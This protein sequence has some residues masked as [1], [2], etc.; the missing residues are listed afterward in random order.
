MVEDKSTQVP[1]LPGRGY[2]LI[3][4]H[5]PQRISV[6]HWKG[7]AV[8]AVTYL[9]TSILSRVF[10]IQPEI[11]APVWLPAGVLLAGL[12][13][14]PW[15]AV[16]PAICAVFLASVAGNWTTHVP[17]VPSLALSLADCVCGLLA[18]IA[19]KE[20]SRNSSRIGDLRRLVSLMLFGAVLANGVGAILGAGI[21]VGFGYGAFAESWLMWFLSSAWGILIVV[22]LV[23]EWGRIRSFVTNAVPQVWVELL[24]VS[25]L[26][27]T[28]VFLVWT[29][30]DVASTYGFVAPFLIFPLLVWTALRFGTAGATVGSFAVSAVVLLGTAHGMGRFA[31]GY[32]SLHVRF[33]EL[34]VFM[35]MATICSLVAAAVMA[36]RERAEVELRYASS[37][38][39][40]SDVAII[41][42]TSDGVIRSWNTGA[43]RLY[44]YKAEEMIGRS[45]S[46][47]LPPN[48]RDE[49]PE[50]ME[51]L[52]RG[53]QGADYDTV[54]QRKD[55]AR[56][57]VYL[58]VSPIHGRNGNV[59]G[60]S[61]IA[62]DIT[63]RKKSERALQEINERLELSFDAARMG[64]W[65]WNLSTG[66]IHWFGNQ[67]WLF[68]IE[69]SFDNRAETAFERIHP[70]DRVR[71]QKEIEGWA[72]E[73]R[74]SYDQ[75]F[76]V[77]WPDG[78]EHWL[79]AKGRIVHE[80]GVP[81]RCLGINL[82]ITDRKLAE[83]A[84]HQAEARLARAQEMS[85]VM[86]LHV[87]L[88]GEFLRVPQRFCEFLGYSHG[89][90]I[91]MPF[92]DVTH[93]DDFSGDWSQC[94]RLVAGDIDSF[95]MEKRFI[96][97]DGSIT[98]G[99]INC[100]TVT[101]EAG[102]PV[103]F[104]TYVLDIN[105]EKRA[106]DALRESEERFRATFENAA[107]GMAQVALDGRW[108]R[109]NERLCEITGYSREEMEAKTFQEITHPDDVAKDLLQ[110]EQLVRGEIGSYSME[111]R[112]LHKD[113]HVV[114]VNLTVSLQKPSADQPAYFISAV[115]DITQRKRAEQAL[116]K[117]EQRL[118]VLTE[119]LPQL[120]W[121]ADAIGTVDYVNRRWC[122]YTGQTKQQAMGNGSFAA[123]H[124]E[125]VPSVEHSWINA[126][127]SGTQHQ[128][129]FRL[130]SK[131]GQYRWFLARGVP[132]R[133]EDGQV[134]RWFGTFTDIHD[135]KMAQ[136][137]LIRS[138]KLASVGRMAMTI[139]HE[140]NNPLAAVMN[141]LF[142]LKAEPGLTKSA[143]NYVDLADGELRRI[144][145]ITRQALG[146]YR[147]STTPAPTSV[148]DLVDSVTEL[149]KSKIK[150]KHV[151]VTK[152]L[153]RGIAVTAVGGEIRQ[154]L[155]NLL[156]NAIDAVDNGGRI[157]VRTS[158]ARNFKGRD[159]VRITVADN[160]KGIS[161][162]S[163]PHI[164]EPFF[165][166][167]D[168]VGTGLG[169]WVSKQ[170]VDKH[171]GCIRVRSWVDAQRHG[172]VFSIVLPMEPQAEGVNC[173][174]TPTVLAG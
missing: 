29:R 35:I 148:N 81:T 149:L 133:S 20:F 93:P 64:A 157:W 22:P 41:G 159:T 1:G 48:H 71:V 144:S 128:V 134:E 53:E 15:S 141:T 42:K 174:A 158:R 7:C 51:R 95:E 161:S 80:N 115:E 92:K 66:E 123:V 151:E 56:I 25:G 34:Q 152:E 130:R 50:I 49:M 77:V 73:N 28:I 8:L 164:F 55:G 72:R 12:L 65:D 142:L 97:K 37:I 13:L 171:K 78:S 38:I 155:S 89:E 131:D 39:E 60:A 63:E 18:A 4:G 162:T 146:F 17:F 129:E 160:G 82:D 96:R 67:Q 140:I 90:L 40:S 114:W 31:A 112:Y 45:V 14:L 85:L 105:K 137:A 58:K 5:R 76:R 24:V 87:S 11:L 9:L 101:D 126:V 19:L 153:S 165:T 120:V 54:R 30:Q 143:M 139:A 106:E 163:L 168:A 94:Q 99:Y 62:R 122:A 118:R 136:Q 52:R 88:N 69:G 47:L 170:I 86:P 119:A 3:S 104:L 83:K 74:D 33:V 113:G 102:K 2:H 132:L 61:S 21:I 166:T 124:P 107:V 121:T 100:S 116:R 110:A 57:D 111:K 147:E 150:A 10:V 26:L 70:Q 154:V 103:H 68:G 46:A 117:S 135:M 59:I 145:H 43:E 109:V 44:G 125:D 84:L 167:K 79:Y 156:S 27:T 32:E 173:P 16:L 108:L 169:L 172:T 138:E 6:R 127:T 75:E 98:W 36:D 23:S 91:G